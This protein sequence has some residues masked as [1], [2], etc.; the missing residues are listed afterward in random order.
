MSVV[1]VG[2]LGCGQIVQ[3]VHLRILRHLPGVR[4][5]ALAERDPAKLKQAGRLAPKAIHFNNYRELLVSP[6]VEAVVIC[7]PNALHAEA[8]MAA[9]EQRKHVYLEKP[10]AMNLQEGRAA[11]SAWKDSGKIGIIGFNYRFHPLYQTMKRRME[12][13]KIKNLIGVRSVFSTVSWPLPEWKQTLETGGGVLTDLASHHVDLVHFMFGRKIKK[14]FAQLTSQMS[15]GDNGMLQFELENGTPIQSF[16]SLRAIDEDR[17]EIYTH[18]KK[19]S[20]NRHHSF[21]WRKLLRPRYEPSYRA[22]LEHFIT[23]IRQNRQAQP[24]F[25]DGYHTLQVIAAAEESVRTG[26]VVS[27]DPV[28]ENSA[29]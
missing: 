14:V 28:Y 4:V 13:G 15:E 26:Q 12:L 24:D 22:S 5:A 25:L 27:V 6:E 2:I 20:L 11:L 21:S 1:K 16:F 17:W 19:L 23:C 7:L 8:A 29:R 18:R 10:L 3:K 9:F